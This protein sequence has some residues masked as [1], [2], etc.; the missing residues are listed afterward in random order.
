[1][2]FR[3]CGLGIEQ[4]L[5]ISRHYPRSEGKMRDMSNRVNAKAIRLELKQ[6]IPMMKKD[7]LKL[8]YKKIIL[9]FK[10]SNHTAHIH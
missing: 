4:Q 2:I 8:S 3:W 6:K 1:M 5:L 10:I 7:I 9:V